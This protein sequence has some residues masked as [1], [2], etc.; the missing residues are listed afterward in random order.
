LIPRPGPAP[1]PERSWGRSAECVERKLPIVGFR[2]LL[3]EPRVAAPRSG[4]RAKKPG[5]TTAP[6]ASNP[7]GNAVITNGG[8]GNDESYLTTTTES[9]TTTG[10][11]TTMGSKW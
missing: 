5:A 10:P 2:S 11:E 4:R 7:M 6:G 8:Q 3:S 1:H 9:E